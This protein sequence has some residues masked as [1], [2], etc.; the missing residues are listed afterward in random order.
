M[1]SHIPTIPFYVIKY[2]YYIQFHIDFDMYPS[3][4]NRMIDF[5]T[6]DD[7]DNVSNK[8]AYTARLYLMNRR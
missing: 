7:D 5:A 3:E 6:V 4:N 2:Q 8:G 1:P